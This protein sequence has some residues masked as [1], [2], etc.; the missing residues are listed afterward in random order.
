MKQMLE[1]L[2]LKVVEMVEPGRMDGGDV[3]FTGR[4]FFVGDSKRTNEVRAMT[5]NKGL[6][7]AS[8]TNFVTCF[9]EDCQDKM[10][11]TDTV[12]PVLTAT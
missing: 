3:L 1:K 6:E 10:S 2:G 4:E 12:E 8:I 5:T 11:D 7:S 9:Q